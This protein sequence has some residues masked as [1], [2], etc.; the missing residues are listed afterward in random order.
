MYG[1][2]VV[3]PNH[4]IDIF[5]KE[6]FPNS[7]FASTLQVKVTLSNKYML[8]GFACDAKMMIVNMFYTFE[9]TPARIPGCMWCE[10]SN[11]V[12]TGALELWGEDHQKRGGQHYMEYFGWWRKKMNSAS[13][14]ILRGKWK[15]LGVDRE[16]CGLE[17]SICINWEEEKST[18]RGSELNALNNIVLVHTW[19]RWNDIL[20]HIRALENEWNSKIQWNT[21]EVW[22]EWHESREG[23]WTEMAVGGH[24]L[25]KDQKRLPYFH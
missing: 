23:R 13:P 24:T 1:A 14:W 4:I 12:T 25:N 8:G 2:I 16:Q 15:R 3:V 5:M 10:G 9:K 22:D 18:C 7:N 6:I 20:F 21:F 17:T 19:A 11:R